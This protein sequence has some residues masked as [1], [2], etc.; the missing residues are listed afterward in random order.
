M[1]TGSHKIIS[2][3]LILTLITITI[4][5][6]PF[7]TGRD[8]AERHS[9][10]INAA[11][12]IKLEVST[13]HLWF[14]EV[15]SGDKN[16]NIETVWLHLDQSEWYA[17]A[18]LDGA[19]YEETVFIPLNDANLR[20]Q[21]EKTI[22]DIHYFRQIAQKRWASKST[23][24]I[25]SD[26]DQ[27]LDLAFSK[28]TTSADNIEISLKKS[29]AADIKKFKERQ[30]FITIFI[31]ILCTVIGGLF[32]RYNN[33]QLK[34]I[35]ALKQN[36]DSA[37][38]SQHQLQNIINGAKLGYWD[39]NYQ[40]GENIVNDEWLSMLGLTRQDITNH[41][42]DW[43]KLIHPNDKEYIENIIQSR[44]ASGSNYMIE[45]RMKH[46]DG[47]WIWLKGSGSVI[48]YDEDTN[49]PL[50]I[51]GTHH[52]ITARK[53][54]ELRERS[55][56]YVLEL[57]TKNEK[58]SVVLEAIVHGVEEENTGMLCSVL[59]LDEACKHLLVGAA[60]SLPDFYNQAI[61]GTEIG[62]GVGSCGTAVFTN[63][64]VVVEDIHHHPYWTSYKDLASKAKLSSCWSEPIR[65][66]Q[67]KVLGTFAIYHRTVNTPTEDNI[68]LIE[69]SAN[70]ASI[71]IE[72]NQANLALKSRDE[73]MRL[74][75]AGAELGFWDWNI[76]KSTVERNERWATMLGYTH[77]EIKQTTNQWS[78]FIHPDDREKAWQSIN[79]V[80]ES[81][82]K[83]HSL[84]YRMLTKEGDVRWIHD[85][86][87]VMQ[88]D[89]DGKPLRMSG[90]HNDITNRKLAEEKLKLAAS[91]FT[92]AR[93]SIIITDTAGIIIDV[94][95]TF[96]AM[97]G[98]S[99]EEAIGQNPRILKSSRQSSEFYNNMWSTL[100]EEGHWQGELWN[101]RK[102]G[103]LF[104]EMKTISAVQDEQGITTHY[105]ALGNDITAIKEHQDQ[106]EHIAHYDILTR[107]P[108]RVLLADRLSQAMLH[109][110]RH[111]E[112]LAVV[113]LD[114]DGFKAVNDTYG[115]DIGDELLVT[116]SIRM[117]EALREGDSL[118]RL[119][120]DEFV[121]V[122]TDLTPSTAANDCEP[123]LSRLLLAASEPITIRDIVLNVSAS[124]GVTLYPQ[125]NVNAD[126]LM[127]HADQAMYVAKE[128]GKNR[129]HL[130][131]TAQDVAVKVQ[132]ESLEAVRSAL[133]NNQFVL[134][135]Q[136]KVNMKTGTVVGVEALIRWQHPERGLLG[137]IEFLPVI[138]N[139]PM[140]VE[141]G[142]WVI[143]TALTQIGEWQ[144]MGLQQPFNTSVNI[145]AVQLQQSDFTERLTKLLSNHS[146]VDPR[147]LE[148][149]V[150]ETS[151]LD[152]V[153]H[154]SAI[155]C[156]CMALGVKF[157]LDDFGTGYSS[158]TYLRRLPAKIIKIDQT[159]V[160]DMLVDTDDLAIVEGVIALAKSFKRDVIAEG[161]ETIEHGTALLQLGCDLA[162]G[163]GIAKP[164]PA[165]DIHTWINN[166]KPDVNWQK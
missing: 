93:E 23:S 20:T 40:T 128:S 56:S 104:V 65:T 161:V 61:H 35:N 136:P 25:G 142:E 165:N 33:K 166:W 39:W 154:V 52:E 137:P 87:N 116:L 149:E 63:K 67:G 31:V 68:A 38:K 113:F 102:N 10:L 59:L 163:Y 51:C 78:D 107:L 58:L 36:K 152:D 79:D 125:D 139:N 13:A 2:F 12:K 118:A 106:L 30:L 50:Q 77:E 5:Y 86:A 150:L 27:A 54:A 109:C 57:I 158:L 138:E 130:F 21:I 46:A 148:L 97:T 17:K 29:I 105:V 134:Y 66:T 129:Y 123:V 64:R 91:V 143:D 126:Q 6:Y 60:P 115:H 14:E 146:N 157:A 94:N 43:E 100:N 7:N 3:I 121:A 133:E 47:R 48:K 9:P 122:L 145:A 88:R 103:D 4:F 1:K 69:Q 18:M 96:T 45:F 95:D 99:R 8:I 162:Q 80:L 155:M 159:F 15:I 34:S 101:Y 22:E 89:M 110:S 44:I 26:L 131:D 98:Y 32:L 11:I 71:A 135:Y 85:Q 41:I 164:M 132:R 75:L 120:G 55:R 119:G 72:K 81:R 147:C 160:R 144:A 19:T 83:S 82:S 53:Q 42:S 112:S 73:Q 49:E 117:Q 70:L 84:E 28:L 140:M 74:V 92:H 156:A 124:I 37:Q 114:L 62:F 108:N 111:E 153:H 151:A 141:L 76:V 24:G 90:I 16:V 127:R